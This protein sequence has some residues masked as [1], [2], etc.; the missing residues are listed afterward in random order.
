MVDAASSGK[1][2]IMKSLISEEYVQMTRYSVVPQSYLAI[3]ISHD[4]GQGQSVSIESPEKEMTPP[5]DLSA[6][7]L[8]PHNLCPQKFLSATSSQSTHP[9]RNATNSVWETIYR[10]GETLLEMDR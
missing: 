10:G 3:S 7:I 2:T 9:F 4:Q 5:H 1:L 6:M 8:E